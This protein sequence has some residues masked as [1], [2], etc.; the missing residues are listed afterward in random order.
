MA[1]STTALAKYSYVQIV[2]QLLMKRP[3]NNP[4]NLNK[5]FFWH[6]QRGRRVQQKVFEFQLNY[7]LSDIG[8][9]IN[10]NNKMFL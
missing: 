5:A 1:G 2:S 6:Q 7:W 4:K 8:S 10:G 9:L 3:H